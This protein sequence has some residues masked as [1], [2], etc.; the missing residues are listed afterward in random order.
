MGTVPAG[1]T[2]PR[3]LTG[4]D[5]SVQRSLLGIIAGLV[6]YLLLVPVVGELV[7]VVGW[8]ARSRPGHFADYYRSASQFH[9]LEGLVSANLGLA[10]LIPLAFAL[11]HF[12]HRRPVAYLNS[13]QPGMR[14]RYL[15]LAAGVAVVALNAVM[16][17][18]RIGTPTVWAPQPHAWAYLLLIVLTS[19]LQ[20]AA[21]EYFFR[22]YL[23]QALGSMVRTPWF[24]V[25]ASAFV[26]A[27]FH[28]TQNAPL[29]LDRF[30]FGLLAGVLVLRTGGLEAGIA[31]H[32][33]NNIFAFGYA[34][35]MGGIATARGVTTLSWAGAGWDLLGFAVFAGLAWLLGRRLQVAT[36]TPG[37]PDLNS[38]QVVG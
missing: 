37:T 20:A 35:M 17:L 36:T 9:Y 28:G 2:Y 25:V 1:V 8:L 4:R 30:G 32:V 34:T 33:V 29:F 7:L 22:G 15:L 16:W 18:S 31:A 12:V 11:V 24:G 19:P 13:V 3:V 6:G 26:F 10:M 5:A 21:E 27:L 38:S 23:M 14:W